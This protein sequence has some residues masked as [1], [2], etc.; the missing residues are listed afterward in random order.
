MRTVNG[1]L[2]AGDGAILLSFALGG[3]RFHYGG[4]NLVVTGL[5]ISLPFLAGYLCLA[6][7]L[8]ALHWR[9]SAASFGGRSLAAWLLGM[10]LGFGLRWLMSGTPPSPIFVQIALLYTATL[11]GLWRTSFWVWGRYRGANKMGPIP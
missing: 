2:V 9:P 3:A 10:A 8:D 4:D 5:R 1:F 7:L 6:L 11:F